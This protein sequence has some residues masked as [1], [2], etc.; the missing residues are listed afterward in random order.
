MKMLFADHEGQPHVP[1]SISQVLKLL[2]ERDRKLR[3]VRS[4]E[5]KYG[6]EYLEKI[7]MV[8]VEDIESIRR[9]VNVLKSG[10]RSNKLGK[11]ATD[12]SPAQIQPS[13]DNDSDVNG[14]GAPEMVEPFQ[15]GSWYADESTPN[16]PRK[17]RRFSYA[18]LNSELP[19]DSATETPSFEE[20][21]SDRSGGSNGNGDVLREGTAQEDEEDAELDHSDSDQ[22][23]GQILTNTTDDAK[24]L[25]V[26][27][28]GK[29]PRVVQEQIEKQEEKIY[30]GSPPKLRTPISQQVTAQVERKETLHSAA[31]KSMDRGVGLSQNRN[32]STPKR[33][34]EKRPIEEELRQ[35]PAVR[36]DGFVANAVVRKPSER[37]A[38]IGSDCR[39]CRENWKF[40]STFGKGTSNIKQVCSKHRYQHARSLTPDHWNAV[41]FTET[42]TQPP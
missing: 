26:S 5:G 4:L 24:T 18:E 20:G 12:T 33:K 39:E 29:E 38:L 23:Q 1:F 35:N 6:R 7:V 31:G 3:K 40:L 37:E 27:G 15:P 32:G 19:I 17:R 10:R 14:D 36:G 34:K 28:A 25:K 9:D 22:A 41:S 42:R 21:L 2:A 13:A 8:L 16:L 30:V 11:L